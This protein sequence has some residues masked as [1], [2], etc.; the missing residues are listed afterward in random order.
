MRLGPLE[1][2]AAGERDPETLGQAASVRLFAERARALITTYAAAFFRA[3][4][5]ADPA[6][7][8]ALATATA[9]ADINYTAAG[10]P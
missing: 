7:R 4:L 10:L 1:L 8:A 5:L 9:P 2:P 3:E 6:A